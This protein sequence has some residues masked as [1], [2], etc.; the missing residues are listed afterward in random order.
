MPSFASRSAVPDSATSDQ[1]RQFLAEA[2]RDLEAALDRLLPP[3][4][5]ADARVSEAMRYAVLSP[6][7]RIRP[8]LLIAVG[9]LY[10]TPRPRTLAAGSAVEMAHACSLILDDL[11][12]MDDA[13]QRRGRAATHRAFGEATAILAAFGLLNRAFEILA[14]EPS[15][16]EKLRSELGR[17]L[18]VALGT[19]G[20][21]AGQALDLALAPERCSL[22]ELERIHSR[23]TGSLFI[24]CVEI[25]SVLG[26]APAAEAEALRGF[27]KNL[28]LAYQIV[29]DLLDASGDPA[30][31]GKAVHKDE[32]GNFVSLSGIEGA[33]RLSQELFECAVDHLASLGR[34]G[35]LLRSLARLLIHREQ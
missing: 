6:G 31:A 14:A 10:A 29:D 8:A 13:D 4:A 11:P 2:G 33:R 20:L 21:T 34:R 12:S 23:K 18:A 28:G 32:R 5:H 24:A 25:G 7:K 3:A 15:I 22:D 26:R 35:A 19:D 1:V 17:R 30:R 16:P 9:D 27:A